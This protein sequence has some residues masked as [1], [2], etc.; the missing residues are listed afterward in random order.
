MRTL[1]SRVQKLR[2]KGQGTLEYLGIAVLIAVL[3]AGLAT[4]PIGD[5]ISKGLR[6]TICKITNSA[7]ASASYSGSV[8][9]FGR[10]PELAANIQVPHSTHIVAG[11]CPLGG[12]ENSDSSSDNSSDT[13]TNTGPGPANPGSNNAVD[14]STNAKGSDTSSKTE[15][16]PTNKQSSSK[17]KGPENG[18]P[19]DVSPQGYEGP[20]VQGEDEYVYD[21][22]GKR[23]PYS[24][25]DRRPSYTEDQIKKVWDASR[26]EQREK[27]ENGNLEVDENGFIPTKLKPNEI[28]VMDK[29]GNWRSVKWEPGDSRRGKWDMGHRAGDEYRKLYK[30]YMDGEISKKQFL[31]EYQEPANYQVEDPGRNRS[32]QDEDKSDKK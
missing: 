9:S 21:K 25:P 32:H 20:F 16:D 4:F 15:S 22:D 11:N 6:G 19:V 23:I 28:Y 30:K 18:T 12:H 8:E 7:S 26:K 1:T 10:T 29:H 5:A 24:N 2:Q 13:S 14:T 27:I 17:K 31:E 3:I